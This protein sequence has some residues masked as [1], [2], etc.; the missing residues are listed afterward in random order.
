MPASW[1][2]KSSTAPEL[3]SDRATFRLYLCGEAVVRGF[4]LGG[5]LLIALFW[6]VEAGP[7]AWLLLSVESLATVV[8]ALSWAA[9]KRA[10]T[11]A[12][13]SAA[14]SAALS[15]TPRMTA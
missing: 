3:Y 15:A 12:A 10:D 14:S 4:E 2:W 7:V 8:G 6:R 13:S 5:C 9:K 11:V 1:C